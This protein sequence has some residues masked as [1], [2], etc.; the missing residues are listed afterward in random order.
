M[1]ESDATKPQ[2]SQ[3][4]TG[5]PEKQSDGSGNR[6]PRGRSRG[7]GFRGRRDSQ[8]SRRAPIT[9]IV[10]LN[11]KIESDWAEKIK[12][13][14]SEKHRSMF[15][16]SLAP[17]GSL[18]EIV[19]E[20]RKKGAHRIMAVGDDRFVDWAAQAMIGSLMPLAPAL[21]PGSKPIF[22]H[23][24]MSNADWKQRTEAL[25][26]G[27]FVK[28]DMVIGGKRPFLHQLVAGFPVNESG[29]LWGKCKALLSKD[30]ISVSC[31]IDRSTISGK[32]WCVVIANS[33]M[34]DGRVRWLH[35]ADWTDQCLDMLLVEPRSFWQRWKFLSKAQQGL[36]GGLPGV[37][38]YRGHRITLNSDT[39]CLY[40]IDGEVRRL[41]EPMILE[42]KPER[43][44]IVLQG[45]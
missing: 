34:T 2:P 15:T 45:D 41:E 7:R 17:D 24:A 44:R 26:F 19:K 27:R 3:S 37:L 36:H 8:R 35:G 42:A 12:V 28:A 9:A 30:E 32:Y 25:L 10:S 16:L 29:Q 31:E 22:G 20:A 4:K 21:V 18:T 38:R 5:G 6:R 14:L 11:T 1:T 33:D 39:K 13:H 40:S 43:L 23:T